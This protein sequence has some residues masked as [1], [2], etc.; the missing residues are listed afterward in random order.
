MALDVKVRSVK[1][2]VEY[3]DGQ[4]EIYPGL[5]GVVFN[6]EDLM[7]LEVIPRKVTVEEMEVITKWLREEL[8]G[9]EKELKR[10]REEMK[11]GEREEGG[12]HPGNPGSSG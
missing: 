9:L 12:N 1:V 11:K 8:R 6:E 7:V 3:E 10:F 4:V 5:V 2:E